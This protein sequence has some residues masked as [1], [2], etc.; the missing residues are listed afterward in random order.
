MGIGGMTTMQRPSPSTAWAF[1]KIWGIRLILGVGESQDNRGMGR[2]KDRL[3][4]SK[5]KLACKEQS[6]N[7]GCL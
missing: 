4:G 5:Q 2:E 1:T 3:F 7:S 6:H